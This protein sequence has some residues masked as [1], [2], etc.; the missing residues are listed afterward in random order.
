MESIIPPLSPSL[1]L[2]LSLSLSLHMVMMMTQ[3]PLELIHKTYHIGFFSVP[4]PREEW[5]H[6]N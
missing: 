5:V 3:C 1:P 6:Y 2:S 4:L